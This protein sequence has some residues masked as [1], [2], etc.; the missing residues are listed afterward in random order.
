MEMMSILTIK[1]ILKAC[2][3]NNILTHMIKIFS[4]HLTKINLNCPD[5]RCIR[6]NLE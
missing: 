5:N 2:K 1:E 4:N 3:E 6:Q